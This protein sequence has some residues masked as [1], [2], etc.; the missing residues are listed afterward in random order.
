MGKRKRE[1]EK[2][3]IHVGTFRD[4]LHIDSC[5][6]NASFMG[7]GIVR[8]GNRGWSVRS[9]YTETVWIES[10]LRHAVFSRQK[11]LKTRRNWHVRKE[12]ARRDE[13]S[14]TGWA[15][16][17]NEE[18][19]GSAKS[20]LI[21]LRRLEKMSA[22]AEYVAWSILSTVIPRASRTHVQLVH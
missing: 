3:V 13:E 10:R 4:I 20:S 5:Q 12:E 21:S 1:R 16:R 17:Y 22:G 6:K 11:K 7:N 14:R 15:I 8:W 18:G 19:W 9:R 2:D